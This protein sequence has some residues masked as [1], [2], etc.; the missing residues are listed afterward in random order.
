M[1]QILP[2]LI[3]VDTAMI[4][5]SIFYVLSSEVE[6]LTWTSMV[7]NSGSSNSTRIQAPCWPGQNA[8]TERKRSCSML[9][10]NLKILNSVIQQIFT[11]AKFKNTVS[12]WYYW[13]ISLFR[14]KMFLSWRREV[15]YGK[16]KR[17]SNFNTL[18]SYFTSQTRLDNDPLTRKNGWPRGEQ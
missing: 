18:Y 9:L 5:S 13:K 1:S 17:H 11:L 14:E 2:H 7:K 10:I 4:I 16:Y 3:W 12:K 6:D 15:K 8:T